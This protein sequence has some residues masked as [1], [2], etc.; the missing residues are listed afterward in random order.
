MPV[1]PKPQ[2]STVEN[3]AVPN[4]SA[5]PAAFGAGNA[6][7]LGDVGS[8]L[9][10]SG[11]STVDAGLE[12]QNRLD[13]AQTRDTAS[14]FQDALLGDLQQNVLTKQGKDAVGA[15]SALQGRIATMRSTY[16]SQL[17]S[18]AQQTLFTRLSSEAIGTATRASMSHEFQQQQEY[19]RSAATAEKGSY[20]NA[21]V[22]APLDPDALLNAV[23]A[24]RRANAT[25]NAG[26]PEQEDLA[27]SVDDNHLFSNVAGSIAKT[28]PAAAL[29]FADKHKDAFDGPTY[30]N[31]TKSFRGQIATT[32]AQRVSDQLSALPPDVAYNQLNSME[33]GPV[34]DM[35]KQLLDS[36]FTTQA[37]GKAKQVADSDAALTRSFVQD[38]GAAPG[39]IPQN[40]PID[41]RV[42]LTG[43]LNNLAK[44]PP[45][46]DPNVFAGLLHT[47]T[48]DPNAFMR[49]SMLPYVDKLSAD[50]M[51]TV[52]SLRDQIDRHVGQGKITV[53]QSQRTLQDMFNS[54]INSGFP[55]DEAAG[56]PAVPSSLTDI[57]ASKL[58]PADQQTR[59]QNINQLKDLFYQRVNNE[60][61]QKADQTSDK[62]NKILRNIVA[63]RVVTS[64]FLGL[65][66]K[67]APGG[68][69]DLHPSQFPEAAA[70][71]A[72]NDPVKRR[73]P[74]TIRSYPNVEE[75]QNPQGKNVYYHYNSDYS[76]ADVYDDQGQKINTWKAN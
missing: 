48:D 6:S 62:V 63:D 27:N 14:Q 30:E 50:D 17:D 33:D 13:L 11:M 56:L 46:T 57:G 1:I 72:Q 24:N 70:I 41:Q 73:M 35:T 8:S 34:K 28:D 9:T 61:P 15:T 31:I 59:L 51:N 4:V 43:T 36:E 45:L 39:L 66:K 64:G 37:H 23:S 12:A 29:A 49:M 53:G 32:A 47:M 2:V 76:Q 74:A 20:L 52:L 58:N 68:L 38:Y 5:T 71:A 54:A 75:Y 55:A 21:A 69:V 65:G 22:A 40:Y 3:A 10:R 18:P 16:A 60:L 44:N 42:Q 19:S 26:F 7:L 67:S 25:L